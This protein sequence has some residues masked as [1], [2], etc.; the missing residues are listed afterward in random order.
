[1]WALILFLPLDKWLALSLEFAVFI[2]IFIYKGIWSESELLSD[3][4]N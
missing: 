1:M 4:E 2:T 3:S